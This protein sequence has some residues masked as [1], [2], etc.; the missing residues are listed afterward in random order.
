MKIDIDYN[1]QEFWVGDPKL[2]DTTRPYFYYGLPNV[3][4]EF[5]DSELECGGY[6]P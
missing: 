2:G 1:L 3:I 5:E 6:I 4:W